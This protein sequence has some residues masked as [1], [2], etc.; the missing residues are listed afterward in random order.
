[1]CVF[2]YTTLAGRDARCSSKTNSK[3]RKQKTRMIGITENKKRKT[4]NIEYTCVYA[5]LYI[6]IFTYIYIHIFTYIHIY[7][8]V[9]IY[10]TFAYRCT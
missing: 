10:N 4:R 3:N 2:I 8:H 5:Y 9:D 7:V 6:Y 1:M